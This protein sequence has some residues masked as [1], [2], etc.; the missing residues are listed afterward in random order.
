MIEATQVTLFMVISIKFLYLL[1]Q[2]FSLRFK[3]LKSTDIAVNMLL[4]SLLYHIYYEIQFFKDKYVSK[5]LKRNE[6]YLLR[7]LA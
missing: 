5:I 6:C 1:G 2:K 3:F 7:V 4:K